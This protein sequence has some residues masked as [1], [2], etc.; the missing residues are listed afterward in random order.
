MVN[1]Q[2]GGS[3][4]APEEAPHLDFGVVRES[5]L[6]EVI[7]EPVLRTTGSK[8]GRRAFQTKEAHMW[9][10]RGQKTAK[11]FGGPWGQGGAARD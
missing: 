6:Q 3:P 1:I 5:F 4:V 10:L 9:Q 8:P 2:L 11:V 7:T